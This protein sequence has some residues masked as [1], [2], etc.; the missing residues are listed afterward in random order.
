MKCGFIKPRPVAQKAK[1]KAEFE[2]LKKTFNVVPTAAE[3]AGDALE[4]VAQSFVGANEALAKKDFPTARRLLAGIVANPIAPPHYRS[5]A[6]LRL[7]QS[8]VATKQVALAKAQLAQ[9]AANASYPSV[10][11]DEAAGCV[12]EL[13]RAATGLPARNPAASRVS[14]RPLPLPR[15]SLF[16]APKGD[17]ANPGTPAKPLASL[18]K[19]RD[20]ARPLLAQK[21]GGV[22]IVLAPGEYRV[23]DT[24]ELNV[25]DGGTSS[26]PIVYRAN[27]AGTAVLYGG[28]RLSGFAPVTDAAILDRLPAEARGKVVQL[29]LKARGISDFGALAVRGFGQPASP[30]TLE[31][32]INGKPMTLA[33]WPNT[34]FVKPTKL[35]E[36]GDQAAGKSSVLGYDDPRPAR[37]TRANDAWMFGYFHFLWADATAKI[38]SIDTAAKTITT[39]QPYQYLGS[40]NNE[41]GIL[42]YVFNLLEEIDRPGEWYLD[43]DTGVLYLYPPSDLS[44]STVEL[45]LLS[46]PMIS[47]T[48]LVQRA[49]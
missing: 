19:A 26:S 25:K 38:G 20:K 39:A 11:R 36:P 1:C 29:D 10:H 2:R 34:G 6:Q 28:A 12:R 13:D 49:L 40:M 14:A 35:L 32:Y 46:R 37:W 33:R 30:P 42:Y 16:V 17:D 24:L 43:R 44:K 4:A 47:A 45:S 5:Y 31:L 27:Q 22:E 21:N 3:K 9:I 15:Y 7:A 23:S 18:Q 48:N 41:Q 8:F